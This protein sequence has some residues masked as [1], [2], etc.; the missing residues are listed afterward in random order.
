ML[1]ISLKGSLLFISNLGRRFRNPYTSAVGFSSEICNDDGCHDVKANIGIEMKSLQRKCD[2][3]LEQNLIS[4]WHRVC[5]DG[6]C[7]EEVS[8]SR[9]QFVKKERQKNSIA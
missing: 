7:K 4:T 3:K 8:P 9:K 2:Q 5:C 6:H 1:K